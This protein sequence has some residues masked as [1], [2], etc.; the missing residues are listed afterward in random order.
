MEGYRSALALLPPSLRQA[1]DSLPEGDKRRCEEFRL[2]RGRPA[3]ALVEERERPFSTLPVSEADIRVVLEAA[4]RSSLHAAAEELRRGY[5]AAPGGVRVGVCGVG[6]SDSQRLTGLR[7]FSSL[8]LR[9]P[10]QVIG[11]ADGIWPSVTAGG[12]ASLLIVS[13]PGAGKTTL[14]RELTRRLSEEGYRVAVADERGEIA[15]A[16]LGE[17][18]FEVGA[19]TDVLT[20]VP[21]AQA[22]MMLLRSMNPQIVAMDEITD[23]ADAAALMNAVGSGVR[24]LATAHGRDAADAAKRP[25]LRRLL[26]LGAFARCA[27][28]ENRNGRRRVVLRELGCG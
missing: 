18:R 9:I 3:M 5:I 11:C 6:V 2:R 25:A 21:R 8:S 4:T 28:V 27:A 26:E 10:R 17:P 24:L 12:F 19:H 20:G 7:A 15:D 1:A 14:L 13:P 16:A 23:E 22:A